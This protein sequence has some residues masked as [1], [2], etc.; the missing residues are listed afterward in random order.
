[1]DA[2]NL[3]SLWDNYLAAK[4]R[5]DKTSDLQDGI[6]AGQAWG[7]FVRAFEDKPLRVIA[8]GRA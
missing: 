3:Q 1:M 8:G 7:A 2:V 5:A 4:A 6:K